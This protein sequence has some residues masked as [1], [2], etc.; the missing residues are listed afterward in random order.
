MCLVKQRHHHGIQSLLFSPCVVC[1]RPWTCSY[2]SISCHACL[3]SVSLHLEVEH[4][5]TQ[6]SSRVVLSLT[7]YINLLP[8]LLHACLI[9]HTSPRSAQKKKQIGNNHAQEGVG[10]G[11]Q[12]AG[13]V[14]GDQKVGRGRRK[15]KKHWGAGEKPQHHHH[16]KPVQLGVRR[17]LSHCT[18]HIPP[19][20][21]MIGKF[22]LKVLPGIVATYYLHVI[23]T[24]HAASNSILKTSHSSMCICDTPVNG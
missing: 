19:S 10:R 2:N 4:G 24:N 1:R 11:R 17:H 15:G 18:A 22:G 8:V 16:T 9:Q 13:Q 7:M 23:P 14:E 5:R 12:P 3:Q 6:S 20:S 21:L